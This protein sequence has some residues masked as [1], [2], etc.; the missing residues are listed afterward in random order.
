[1]SWFPVFLHLF[2][3]GTGASL[4]AVPF[5]QI[6]K[7]YFNFHSTILLVL[8]AAYFLLVRSHGIREA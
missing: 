3:L 6:G 7:Y 8:V 1:M 4:L 5:K 2:A